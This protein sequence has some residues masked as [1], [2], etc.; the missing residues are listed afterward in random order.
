[1]TR[2]FILAV[3]VLF[4][5]VVAAQAVQLDMGATGTYGPINITADTTLTMPADG[6]FQVS[7]LTVAAGAT[8]R[9]VPNLHNTPVVIVATG[10]V[11]ING[12]IDVSGAPGVLGSGGAAGPGGWAG[13]IPA[14]NPDV[15]T[16]S[17]TGTLW[18]GDGLAG[19][20]G[21][22]GSCAYGGVSCTTVGGGGG[23]GGGAITIIS[24]TL[25]RASQGSGTINAGGGN[26]S[27]VLPTNPGSPSS[28]QA[29]SVNIAPATRGSDGSVRLA[30]PTVDIAPLTI[31]ASGATIERLNQTGAPPTLRSAIYVSG[32]PSL[33]SVMYSFVPNPLVARIVSV[34]GVALSVGSETFSYTYSPTAITTTVVTNVTGCSGSLYVNLVTEGF[35]SPACTAD[36]SSF[37]NAASATSTWTCP[38]GSN[39]SFGFL[40]LAVTCSR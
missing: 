26:A 10:D 6:V 36:I 39:Y 35:V 21:G 15:R 29:T 12:T 14:L 37:Q 34:D 33:S 23:G 38:V 25:I 31:V 27:S 22:T 24:N 16:S 8:L 7:T 1:M 19:G 40:N 32:S 17:P 18:T 2:R 13:H 3:A 5:F 11:L 30:A 9:F 4:P 28:C 20:Y